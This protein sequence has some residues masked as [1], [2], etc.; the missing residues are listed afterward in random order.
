MPNSTQQRRQANLVRL[1]SNG[2]SPKPLYQTIDPAPRINTTAEN[3]PAYS[4][5]QGV[6]H[7]VS[8]LWGG[9]KGAAET[10]MGVI[11]P[12][13]SLFEN[14]VV[15][16]RGGE[17]EE[18]DDTGGANHQSLS[19]PETND[20]WQRIFIQDRDGGKA[21]LEVFN[22]NF[23][24]SDPRR[25]F[26]NFFN[27]SD[28]AQAGDVEVI[29]A[30][31]DAVLNQTLFSKLM[32]YS[33]QNI[34]FPLSWM[35][36][37]NLANHT[38]VSPQVAGRMENVTAHCDSGTSPDMTVFLG[39]AAGVLG[40]G[41]LCCCLYFCA[42]EC[43]QRARRQREPAPLAFT[44]RSERERRRGTPRVSNMPRGT[45][46]FAGSGG[47]YQQQQQQYQQRQ[48]AGAGVA[49]A[50]TPLLGGGSRG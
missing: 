13:A 48:S 38:S 25:N 4:A 21:V 46:T 15:G 8:Q 3:S 50:Y 34:C 40:A 37:S 44:D 1:R 33:N 27:S 49:T 36:L 11:T 19:S 10:V 18:K 14:N 2:Q 39:V 9:V 7:F 43:D 45:T 26:T 17:I 31:P 20:Y 28:M 12:P 22:Y 41:V 24:V 30:L 47:G 29:P 6:K 35:T 32:R 5:M 42:S 23:P 16:D